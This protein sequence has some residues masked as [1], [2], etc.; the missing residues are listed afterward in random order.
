MGCLL[1][2]Y[3]LGVTRASSIHLLPGKYLIL[4]MFKSENQLMIE[5]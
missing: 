1:C 4:N 3:V 5:P 2:V